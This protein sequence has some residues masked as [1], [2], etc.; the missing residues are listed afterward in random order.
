ME[1]RLGFGCAVYPVLAP[2][3]VQVVDVGIAVQHVIGA[4]SKN[5]IV[6]SDPVEMVPPGHPRVT[7]LPGPPSGPRLC[8][9]SAGLD[10]R[11]CRRTH[12]GASCSGEKSLDGPPESRSAPVLPWRRSRPDPPQ[13]RTLPSERRA[14][15][16]GRLEPD[17]A[18]RPGGGCHWRYSRIQARGEGLISRPLP[19][20]G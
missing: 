1:I 9:S 17:A 4:L 20:S 15:Q 11:P 6:V 5:A 7:S 10:R 13:T 18:I 12:I 19:T 3:P 2:A 14:D 16:K 8:G